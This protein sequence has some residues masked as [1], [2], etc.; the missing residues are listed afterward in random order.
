MIKE[1]LL[2]TR[3]DNYR[4]SNKYIIILLNWYI[5][6][7]SKFDHLN[8]CNS[9]QLSLFLIVARRRI[10]ILSKRL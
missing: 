1:K 3:I 10:G 6:R 7:T 4:I 5:S 8:L 9:M 2:N